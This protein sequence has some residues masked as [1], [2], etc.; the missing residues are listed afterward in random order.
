MGKEKGKTVMI[1]FK[2][3]VVR[4]WREMMHIQGEV[5]KEGLVFVQLKLCSNGVVRTGFNA[6]R[7]YPIV[8]KIILSDLLHK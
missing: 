4:V 3:L 6:D 2:E 1:S 5:S 7:I 8:K